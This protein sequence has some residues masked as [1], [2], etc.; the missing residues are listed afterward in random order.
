ME[1]HFYS[2]C[3]LKHPRHNFTSSILDWGVVYLRR[4]LA[5][6]IVIKPLPLW[7]LSISFRP[8]VFGMIFTVC[9]PSNLFKVPQDF[10]RATEA[11]WLVQ[12]DLQ[13][14]PGV[15]NMRKFAAALPFIWKA[16]IWPTNQWPEAVREMEAC[17]KWVLFQHRWWHFSASQCTKCKIRK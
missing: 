14:Y 9:M 7:C 2:V 3:S 16:I 15:I 1:E 5:L 8:S 6:V 10:T 11:V 17:D 12:K 4:R 13:I